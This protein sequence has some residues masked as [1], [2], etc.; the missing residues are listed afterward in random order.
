MMNFKGVFKKYKKH[1]KKGYTLVE[2]M[3]VVALLTIVSGATLSV[4]LMVG[5]VTRD[6]GDITTDQFNVTHMEKLI[7]NEFQSCSNVNVVRLAEMQDGGA[8]FDDIEAGDEYMMYDANVKRVSF[9]RYEYNEGH[10]QLN[11]NTKLTIDGVRSATISIAPLDI[12]AASPQG[13]PFKLF[14]SIQTEHEHYTYSGGIVLSNTEY[15]GSN[16]ESM[17][18]TLADSKSIQWLAAEDNDDN[19]YVV[20]FHKEGTSVDITPP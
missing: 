14:Y 11:A 4:F 12:G 1:S 3:V 17:K 13:Q 15:N 19:T 2:L 20:S 9:V 16:D 6:A 5:D 8:F 7:R 10:T 18:R